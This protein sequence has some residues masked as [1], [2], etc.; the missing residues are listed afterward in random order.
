[1][2]MGLL[3][4]LLIRA[5]IYVFIGTA[6][7]L[8]LTVLGAVAVVVLMAQFVVWLVTRDWPGW[9][10]KVYRRASKVT[11]LPSKQI[12]RPSSKKIECPSCGTTGDGASLRCR[13]CG[14]NFALAEIA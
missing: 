1:M 8:V 7:L 4:Y 12:Q 5:V 6:A 13:R 2:G 11:P 10:R 9:E 3:I 14:Y